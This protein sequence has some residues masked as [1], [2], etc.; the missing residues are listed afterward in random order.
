[1]PCDIETLTLEKIV[2]K[3]TH[4]Y[5]D[6]IKD[7]GLKLQVKGSGEDILVSADF[8]KAAEAIKNVLD[9]AVRFTE[10]GTISIEMKSIDHTGLVLVKDTGTGIA[11][12]ILSKLFKKELVFDNPHP[13][14]GS[15]LGLYI[16][17]SFMELQD[18]DLTVSSA[19][20]KGSTFTFK[21]PRSN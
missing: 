6:Q 15:G 20:G 3:A 21:F 12:P 17:K 19:V 16:A 13:Q 2:E 14:G 7:K 9:N 11:G 4:G 18:G 10:R 1:M 8:Q 5:V